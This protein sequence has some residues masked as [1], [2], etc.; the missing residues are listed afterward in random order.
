MSNVQPNAAQR[1]L[2]ERA[3]RNGEARTVDGN[4]RN[5]ARVLVRLELAT[6]EELTERTHIVRP[7]EAG[8]ALVAVAGSRMPV[9]ERGSDLG[10]DLGNR[11]HHPKLRRG[12]GE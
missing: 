8:R 1:A 11:R 4:E 3:V 6:V 10:L 7:T 9:F 12:G 5:T 2:L